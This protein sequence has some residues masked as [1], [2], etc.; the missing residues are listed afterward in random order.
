MARMS[1]IQYIYFAGPD[2]FRPDALAW[3]ETVRDMCQR[4][5][6]VA[7]LP[8]DNEATSAAE[9]A[10]ANLRLLRKADAVIANLNP[11]R[12]FEPDSGT[13]FEVG[14]AI[15][16]GKPVF[17]YV[18]DERPLAE[19]LA[20]KEPLARRQDGC[21]CDDRQQM[22]E[23]FGLPLNLMLAT[24]V[25]LIGGGVAQALATLM[26]ETMGGSQRKAAIHLGR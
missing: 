19:R 21:L 8:V 6:C 3:A 11:F 5:G 16:S 14:F 20:E 13:V 2:V 1:A 7:L 23:D 26:A 17:A 12:G 22:V 15:A 24:T 9:I 4:E 18:D 25:R 10:A